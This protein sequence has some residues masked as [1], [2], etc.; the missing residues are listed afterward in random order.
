MWTCERVCVVCCVFLC[1]C[2]LLGVFVCLKKRKKST[3]SRVVRRLSPRR[4]CGPAAA[5]AEAEA[6]EGEL[7]EEAADEAAVERGGW[8]SHVFLFKRCLSAEARAGT[9]SG[10]Q[11]F[12]GCSEEFSM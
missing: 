8:R 7:L 4:S 5:H 2:V 3:T 9:R 1:V 10:M 11:N 6:V 12:A